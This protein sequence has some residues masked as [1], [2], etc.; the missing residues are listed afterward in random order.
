M[1]S[2][3]IRS[4]FMAIATI[5]CI[6]LTP[7]Q[8]AFAASSS[9]EPL[10]GF[11]VAF[12]LDD[13]QNGWCESQQQ[14]VINFFINRQIPLTIGIIGNRFMPEYGRGMTSFLTSPPVQAAIASGL[15]E[16]ANHSYTHP[17]G[18]G[19]ANWTQ[20]DVTTDLE[21]CSA[22]IMSNG[23]MKVDGPHTFIPPENNYS[24]PMEQGVA[25]AGITTMSAQCDILP[26]TTGPDYC[27]GP[28]ATNI[29]APNLKDPAGINQ[30][31][32]GAVLDDW[33]DFQ[34]PANLQ[35]A[36][37]WADRQS[38]RQGFA[39]FMLHPQEF[40]TDASR[41]STDSPDKWTAL[42]SL[43]DYYAGLPAKFYT[44]S[45]MAKALGGGSAQC[46][47]PPAP[48]TGCSLYTVKTGNF[49]WNIAGAL[50]NDGSLWSTA[51]Y[52]DPACSTNVT[53]DFCGALQPGTAI[54]YK[55]P[56]AK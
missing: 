20:S 9:A 2:S 37:E 28:C 6:I 36:K 53:S 49:C 33:T 38:T 56:S 55:C 27:P 19:M 46:A 45:S 7:S 31:A 39:V 1:F 40:T 8:P 26:N 15:I 34:S 18:G 11:A 52:Q 25:A 10:R 42:N 3:E 16:I 50:C 23:I 48:P 47:N 14:K 44:L 41:C 21:H 12:R 4:S 17:E 35:N 54:Y 24:G 32:A 5:A 51:L 22:I 29:F 13:I 43:L 30:L